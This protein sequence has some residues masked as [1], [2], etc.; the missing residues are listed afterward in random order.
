MT[1]TAF[2]GAWIRI[3]MGYAMQLPHYIVAVVGIVLAVARWKRHPK[4]SMLA[5][6]GFGASLLIGLITVPVGA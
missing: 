2:D 3:L 6:I 4:V 5:L 1:S